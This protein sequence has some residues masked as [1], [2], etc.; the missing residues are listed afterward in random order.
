MGMIFGEFEKKKKHNKNFVVD[1]GK[2]EVT[3][4]IAKVEKITNE[5]SKYHGFEKINIGMEIRSDVEQKFKKVYLWDTIIY[6]PKFGSRFREIYES[7]DFDLNIERSAEMVVDEIRNEKIRVDVTKKQKKKKLTSKDEKK[8]TWVDERDSEGNLIYKN[9]I[10]E[11]LPSALAIDF[12]EDV[13]E[14]TYEEEEKMV[15]QIEE[16][17]ESIE[18]NSEN[19]KDELRILNDIEID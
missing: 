12:I 1:K 9:E 4:K 2:Y 7:L 11:Y 19:E 17:S 6:H 3:I 14:E 8:T 5:K 15:E 10:V 16:F 13:S 18:D